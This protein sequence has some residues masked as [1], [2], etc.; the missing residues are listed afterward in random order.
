MADSIE[1]NL[2]DQAKQHLASSDFEN[3]AKSAK[4]V[5]ALDAENSDA[6]DILKASEAVI[7]NGSSNDKSVTYELLID[8]DKVI[9]PESVRLEFKSFCTK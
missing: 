8:T 1:K 3:A 2:L 4:A 9:F 5:L 7:G 6:T